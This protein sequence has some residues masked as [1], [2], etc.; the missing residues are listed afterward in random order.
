MDKVHTNWDE[1]RNNVEKV[2][3]L[4]EWSCSTLRRSRRSNTYSDHIISLTEQPMYIF[5]PYPRDLQGT[6]SFPCNIPVWSLLLPLVTSSLRSKY[7]PRLII[8]PLGEDSN[9][10]DK[11]ILTFCIHT[12]NKM[13]N[14]QLHCSKT[15][16]YLIWSILH[17]HWLLFYPIFYVIDITDQQTNFSPYLSLA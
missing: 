15:S 8:M 14:S 13:Y 3:I 4:N 6:H 9:I 1:W 7:S 2:K 11:N 10:T 5:T 12:G 16:P 17:H